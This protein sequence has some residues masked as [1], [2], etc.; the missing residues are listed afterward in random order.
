MKKHIT[1]FYIETLLMI[2]VLVV[3]M[4]VLSGVFGA[5][6]AKSADAK[7]LTKAVSLAESAAEAVSASE[8]T[9]ELRELLSGLGQ[10]GM[11]GDNVTLSD[12]E[13]RVEITWEPEN[14]IVSSAVTVFWRD[15]E[16][17]SLETAVCLG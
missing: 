8:S 13:Y 10:T 6:R 1:A 15:K 7:H 16:I 3:V 9:G 14:G 4:V 2:T 17:Y 5:A 12:G 11:D